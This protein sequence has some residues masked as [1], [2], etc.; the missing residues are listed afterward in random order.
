M[1][2]DSTSFLERFPE[3]SNQEAAVITA[4]IDEAKRQ[5]DEDLWGDKYDDAINY[6]AAHLLAGRTQA[7]G[8]QIGIANSPR[9]T[10]YI[11][12]AGYTFADTQ[13]GATYLFLREGLVNLTGF[14][15]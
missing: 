9:T 4:T 3:F 15:Y 8:S 7:I 11:G 5:N 1:A 12:A 10:K 13:Y 6:M 14:S 2:V